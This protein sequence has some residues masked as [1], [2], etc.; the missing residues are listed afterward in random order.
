MRNS[1]RNI[2]LLLCTLL[3]LVAVPA[4]AADAFSAADLNVN[5]VSAG[6]TPDE[7]R[8]ALGD[9]ANAATSQQAATGQSQ[10]TWQYDGLTLVFTEGK[11]SD[12]QWSNP[13]LIGP[14]GLRVGD[15]QETVLKAFR[16]D[17][18][19]VETGV[20]YSAG[21]V[22]ATGAPLPPCGVLSA[23]GDAA[24]VLYLAPITPYGADV[25]ADPASYVYQSHASL[26]LT[27]SGGDRTVSAIRWSLG[28][29]AE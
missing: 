25:Q 11:L 17:T 1:K 7:V 15:G 16:M 12:A 20:L 8:A 4:L 6:A 2:A 28:A 9:P 24:Q 21:T 3:L 13:A 29:L 14:R 18:A 10:E 26:T 27:L 19:P 22:A 23:T 5:T